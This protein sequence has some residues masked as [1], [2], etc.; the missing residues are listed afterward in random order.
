MLT[1]VIRTVILFEGRPLQV[2]FCLD[3]GKVKL[4]S[5]ASLDLSLVCLAVEGQ[6]VHNPV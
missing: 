1:P 4:L 5:I 6:Y 2:E 3:E